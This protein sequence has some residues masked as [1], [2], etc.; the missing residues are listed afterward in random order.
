VRYALGI[1]LRRWLS[2]K[3]GRITV[4]QQKSRLCFNA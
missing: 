2:A 3:D 1:P 4:V